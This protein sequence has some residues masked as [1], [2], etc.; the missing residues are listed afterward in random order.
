MSEWIKCGNRFPD[1]LED[2]LV[3]DVNW[4]AVAYRVNGKWMPGNV[5]SES[6]SI[7][8]DFNPTHWQPLPP[9]PEQTA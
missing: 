1:D 4:M 5:D 3:S 8:L 9:P 6:N 7:H 2:V